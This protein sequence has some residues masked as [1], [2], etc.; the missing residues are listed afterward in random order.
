MRLTNRKI[1]IGL[2]VTWS[3]V[4]T[5]FFL[6]FLVMEKPESILLFQ[7]N[8][9]LDDL[10]NGIVRDAQA[11]A[12]THLAMMDTDQVYP[13]DTIPK[14]LRHN[15]PIVGALVNR[16]YPPFDALM[17][18]G[19]INNFTR[20]EDWEKDELVEVDATGTG[21]LLIRIDVFDK[22]KEP[23]FKFI[24]NPDSTIGGI[25]GEDFYFC[26]KAREAGI[27]IYVDTSVEVAHLS[28]NLA[29]TGETRELYKYMKQMKEEEK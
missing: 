13:A 21:C 11:N 15:L 26:N 22:L 10:R 12:C 4:P 28:T 19:K 18:R 6:S 16:R 2:P 20:V 7:T 23:W 8:G 27:P 29:V 3:M 17:F 5:P 25:V 14:L 24:P 1:G 9:Q